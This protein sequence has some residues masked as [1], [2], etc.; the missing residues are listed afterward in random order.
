M[1]PH[2]VTC[3]ICKRDYN[4]D[5]ITH[6]CEHA[7][8]IERIKELDR[9]R[10]VECCH[11][12]ELPKAPAREAGAWRACQNP[13]CIC[14]GEEVASGT[15]RSKDDTIQ[16][17]MEQ[18]LLR[19]PNPLQVNFGDGRFRIN[20][21]K[22]RDGQGFGVILKDTGEPHAIGMRDEADEDDHEHEPE[23]GEIYLH[24]ANR[25]SLNVVIHQLM[26]SAECQ[27]PQAIAVEWQFPSIAS[28]DVAISQDE[29]EEAK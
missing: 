1:M 19:Y 6:V 21:F 13:A 26:E 9:E 22:D 7:S 24:F 17:L 23:P 10:G 14:Y 29:S 25:E 3:P 28:D 18:F 11:Q 5:T 8:L 20:I 2:F 4:A 15:F 12:C 27:D 16:R